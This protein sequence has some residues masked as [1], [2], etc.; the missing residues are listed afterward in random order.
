MSLDTTSLAAPRPTITY[1]YQADLS[2]ALPGFDYTLVT[3]A[4]EV[5]LTPHTAETR[6]AA[7]AAEPALLAIPDEQLTHFSAAADVPFD[8]ACRVHIAGRPSDG[9]RPAYAHLAAITIPPRERPDAPVVQTVDYVSTARCFLFHH[10]D[11]M[12]ETRELADIVMEHMTLDEEADREV[13][14][15]ALSMKSQG[16]PTETKDCGWAQLVA[17]ED[18]DG[19]RHFLEQPSR[20]TVESARAAMGRIQ[21]TTKNDFRLQDRKWTQEAG[22]SVVS[23]VQPL[24]PAAVAFLG[25]AGADVTVKPDI[26]TRLYGI[27][28]FVER[29]SS[30][31]EGIRAHL[32]IENYF[33]RFLGAYIQFLDTDSNIMSTPDWTPDHTGQP[34]SYIQQRDDLRWLDGLGST[35]TI[36]G[37]PNPLLPGL[38]ERDI[39]F[40]EGAVAA[41]LYALG[42]GTGRSPYPDPTLYGALRTTIMNLAI[43][44]LLLPSATA[45]TDYR[46]LKKV[47]DVPSVADVVR[48]LEIA[49]AV[50]IGTGSA[51]DGK[52][53][54]SSLSTI[55]QE[56]FK[57]GLRPVLDY[58]VRTL[59][60]KAVL[61]AAIP[62]AGWIMAAIDV[63]IGIA[64][65][66]Q[67]VVA[68]ATSPWAI[69]NRL[70][71]SLQSVVTVGPDP[72]AGTFPR[73]RADQARALNVRL[74]YQSDQPTMSITIPI[75]PD[76]VETKL[77]V[78]LTNNLGGR[79]KFQCE[80]LV[81][82]EVAGSASTEWLRNEPKKTAA[83]PLLLFQKRVALTAKSVYDHAALL[84]FQDGRY[85]W[86]STGDAPRT[87]R[88]NRSAEGGKVNAISELSALSLSQRHHQLGYAWK[89]AGLGIAECASGA[90]G[91]Q[92]FGLQNVDIPGLPMD[93]TRFSRCGYASLAN[94]VYDSFPPRFKMI[95][96]RY[97]L[98]EQGRPKP[99]PDSRDLGLY[100][101]DPSFGNRPSQ[102]GG[103]Y[104]LRMIPNSGTAPIN[105]PGDTKSYGRFPLPVNSVVIHPSGRVLAINHQLSE[106][107]VTTLESKG[108][109]DDQVPF[110]R[111]IGGPALDYKPPGGVASVRRRA[112][113]LA[114]PIAVAATY[115]GTVIVLESIQQLPQV[116]RLQAFDGNGNPVSTFRDASGVWSPFLDLPTGR[117][118]L[119]LTVAG[120]TD[121]TD[122]FILYYE[123]LGNAPADYHLDIYQTGS[124]VPPKQENPLVTTPGVSVAALAV[125]L[126][127]TLYTLNWSM[128]TDGKGNLAG[129]RNGETG[130][131]GRTVPSLSQW[132]PRETA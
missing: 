45:V 23:D 49:N 121:L 92:L 57:S 117:H 40:P 36:F 59:V 63:A 64:Q 98:D 79:V 39:T 101:V 125:D 15:L 32:R 30:P 107:M 43:P 116:S 88:A 113:L 38:I 14:N 73:G 37:A 78:R 95:D 62:F 2:D 10:P 75:A 85:Q 89:A 106:L 46:E 16:P 123:G 84:T 124:K 87:T 18:E 118:Y 27:R 4:G 44:A 72:V 17:F 25:T 31:G 108:C 128:T 76:S 100:Y 19:E 28:T 65:I 69:Q 109:P 91:T 34:P 7:R 6:A 96:G 74:I 112:G 67:T 61:K 41:R 94:I 131:A 126:F 110:A 115:D 1:V 42:L 60:A 66:T 58:L 130:P 68:V 22:F 90:T 127:R 52:V 29:P 9:S 51:V 129:P 103:G 97:D 111:R 50:Y 33:L 8:G 114:N 48:A 119:G 24:Q 12:S 80:F 53:N 77:T 102:Q 21:L 13:R 54:W 93:D 104:H 11:L 20:E 35:D 83:V 71:T 81:G 82:T 132:L 105:M 26:A 120:N 99:D 56:L 122:I 55:G 70:A 47:F 3:N 5:A 86:M